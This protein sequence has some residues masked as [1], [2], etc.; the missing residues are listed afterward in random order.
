MAILKVEDS[1]GKVL[2]S[3]RVRRTRV[4]DEKEAYVVNWMICDMNGF[5][6]RYA[7]R[8]FYIKRINFVERQEQQMVLKIC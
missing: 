1:K 4:I 3:L 6:D 7:N 2:K 8:S 5:N